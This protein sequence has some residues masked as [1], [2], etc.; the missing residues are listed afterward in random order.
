MATEVCLTFAREAQEETPL[1]QAAYRMAGIATCQIDLIE[2]RWSCQLSSSERK[3]PTAASLRERFLAVLND[4][5]LREQIERRT[6]PARDVIVA[7]AFGTLARD[8]REA[9]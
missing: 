7:L 8:K 2:G 3:A 4:E 9:A 6:G 1:R 5:N